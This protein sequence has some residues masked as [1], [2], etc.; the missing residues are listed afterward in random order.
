MYQ[1]TRALNASASKRF[2]NRRVQ[3]SIGWLIRPASFVRM[4]EIEKLQSAFKKVIDF[5]FAD[6]VWGEQLLQVEVRE[7]AVSHAGGQKRAQ[8]AGVNRSHA[9]DFLENDPMQRIFKDTGIKQLAD[10]QTRPALDQ[11]RAEKTQRISLQVNCSVFF[12]PKH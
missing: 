3:D 7:A 5:F 4:A 9:A 10:L 2:K 1:P 6:F 11:H 8:L 12:F